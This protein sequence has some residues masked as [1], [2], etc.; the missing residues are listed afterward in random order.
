MK[1]E[2]DASNG[3]EAVVAAFAG[4]RRVEPPAAVR[5]AFG[6]NGLKV[7][8]RIFAMLVRGAMVVKLPRKRVAEL[9]DSGRGEPFDAGKGRPMKEW[10]TIRGPESGWVAIAR[11]ARRFVE[12]D[13]AAR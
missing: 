5:K 4:D 6:A 3:F 2:H 9:I 11:E 8:G 1:E 13:G 12:N 10:V 7:N